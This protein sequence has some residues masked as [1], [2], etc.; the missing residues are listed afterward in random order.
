MTLKKAVART[1]EH[2]APG[3]QWDGDVKSENKAKWFLKRCK[4]RDK[5]SKLEKASR[6][7]NRK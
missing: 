2:I 3:G 5:K 4:K 7:R 6:K 1:L